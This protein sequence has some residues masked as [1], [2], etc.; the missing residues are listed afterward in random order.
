[1]QSLPIDSLLPEIIATLRQ[2][3][4]LVLEAPPGA[5][6]TTRV[7]AALLAAE[8]AGARDVLVLEPRRLAA[9]MAARRVAEERNETIGQTV[10]YQVRFEEIAGPQTR[11]RF[12]TEGVLTR[13]L[14]SDPRLQNVGIVVL[15]PDG[16]VKLRH[17]GPPKKKADIKTPEDDVLARLKEAL[18]AQEPVLAPAPAF[19][20][21][22]LDNAACLGKTCV[23]VLLT[24]PVNKTQL[25][26]VEGGFAGDMAAS[27]KQMQDPNIRFAGLVH[28][29]DT[30]LA[31]DEKAAAK[32]RAVLVG[33]LEGLELRQWKTLPAAPELRAAFAIP[34][35][36]AALVVIDAEG[37]LAMRELGVVQMYK[38]G[39]LS[40]LLGVDLGD[41]RE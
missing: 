41:R 9:R 38:F 15:G 11:L 31:A 6:K 23:F 10:G 21:G 24:A 27:V 34:E 17:S 16:A 32:V 4:N 12:V 33:A 29:S 28:D 3:S 22:E 5:G 20:L 8:L 36:Q 2:S 7:P 30:K 19:K 25:P 13:R 40:D 18:G 35:G 26:G 37:K 14:L 1:M 39:R